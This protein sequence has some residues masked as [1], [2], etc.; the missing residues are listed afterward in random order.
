MQQLDHDMDDLLRKA[1]EDYPLKTDIEDWDKLAG[2]ILVV[3]ATSVVSKNNRL[4][5]FGLA[6]LA[7][8]LFIILG[9]L[10]YYDKPHNINGKV[11]HI[12]SSGNK[13]KPG[14]YGKPSRGK[15]DMVV[16]E[17]FPAL[18]EIIIPGLTKVVSNENNSNNS[19]QHF[20]REIIINPK[21]SKHYNDIAVST[22]ED[23]SSHSQQVSEGTKLIV[24]EEQHF[25]QSTIV[26]ASRFALS[27]AVRE[28]ALQFTPVKILSLHL[29]NQKEFYLALNAGIEFS[30]ITSQASTRP[31]YKA[32]IVA[33][34]K[35][36]SKW[37][38]EAGLLI[39]ESNYHSDGR[40]FHMNKI[41]S[42]MPAGMEILWIDGTNRHVEIPVL[43]KYN[44]LHHRHSDFYFSG[45]ILSDLYL[46]EK[47]HYQTILNGIKDNQM[48]LYKENNFSLASQLRIGIG[49]EHSL[50]RSGSIRI[51]PYKNIPLQKTGMGSMTIFSSGINVAA[52]HFFR[53]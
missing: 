4:K 53:R 13:E 48:G 5:Y 41:A 46:H 7:I 16:K 39:G 37:S 36:N 32:G 2:K 33:G 45:G 27:F 8:L 31:G 51:E 1:A 40:Y 21:L 14:V 15:N 22:G 23:H 12:I 29:Q 38:V 3:P 42:S 17:K 20:I 49:Y 28:P 11:E 44:F 34:Y 10:Y 25:P 24:S 9:G 18:K 26:K 35:L 43:I 52:V 30:K 50:G 47:N 19:K 6:L